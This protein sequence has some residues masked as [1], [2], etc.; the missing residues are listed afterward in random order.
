MLAAGNAFDPKV[1]LELITMDPNSVLKEHVHKKSHSYIMAM[2]GGGKMNLD[3]KTY[4]FGPNDQI[5][6]PAGTWH[7]VIAGPQG[8]SF[9]TIN[10]PPI[11][12]E[13]G[14]ERDTY[15]RE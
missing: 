4:E 12:S 3:G 13:D 5:V 14:S 11:L 2:T 8:C 1:A 6:I 7:D 9:Y 15:F 10:V